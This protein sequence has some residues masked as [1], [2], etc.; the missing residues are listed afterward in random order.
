MTEFLLFVRRYKTIGV[1]R[2]KFLI[3]QALAASSNQ[4]LK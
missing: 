3:A 2:V 4:Y 1:R